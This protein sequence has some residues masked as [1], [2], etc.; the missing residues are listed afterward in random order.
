MITFHEVLKLIDNHQAVSVTVAECA[1]ALAEEGA[2]PLT[3]NP[4]GDSA[5]RLL[6]DFRIRAITAATAGRPAPGL[7]EV[8]DRLAAVPADEHVSLFHFGTAKRTFSV[9]VRDSGGVVLG[10]VVLP[11]HT[12]AS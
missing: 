1:R 9:F 6:A 3:T 11:R 10:C 4:G 5:R 12:G 2:A 7:A 8:L